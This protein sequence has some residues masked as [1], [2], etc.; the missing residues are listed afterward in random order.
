M[1]L[2]GFHPPVCLSV[3]PCVRPTRPPLLRVY[4]CGSGG[5]EMLIDRGGRRS[6]VARRA[7]GECGQ[8]RVVSGRSQLNSPQLLFLVYCR[9]R[10]M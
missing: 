8:C 4:C 7:A 2:S 3:R 6:T 5:Q 9:H 10:R 1:Q